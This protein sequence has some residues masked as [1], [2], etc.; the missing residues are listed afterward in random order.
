MR[1][2]AS[3][4][5]TPRSH[6]IRPGCPLLAGLAAGGL[7][8]AAGC[9]VRDEEL[10]PRPARA[11]WLPDSLPSSSLLVDG[12]PAEHAAVN[13]AESYDAARQQA[14]AGD[15]PLL[16]VF[17]AAWCRWSGEFSQGPL[18]ERRVIA[19]SRQFVCTTVDADRDAAV[20]REFRV[21][22]FPTVLLIDAGGQERFRASGVTA[23]SQLP[24]AMAGVLG[25]PLLRT[26]R[27]ADGESP[28]AR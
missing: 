22:A 13:F 19:M 8:M 18:S 17:R 27:V 21:D 24:D 1:P 15:R 4:C 14:A 16:L 3:R 28:P 23:T 11:W 5:Q 25:R 7:L 20:C 9:D 2:S 26:D 6:A 10:L 12:L